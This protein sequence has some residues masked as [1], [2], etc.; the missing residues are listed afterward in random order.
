MIT[1]ALS[2]QFSPARG[3]CPARVGGE[4]GQ[5]ASLMRGHL[6]A[7]P[8]GGAGDEVAHQPG[9]VLRPALAQRRQ[10]DLHDLDR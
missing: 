1:T 3:R 9:D 7:V 2:R 8:L 6:A 10:A 5:G 4:A